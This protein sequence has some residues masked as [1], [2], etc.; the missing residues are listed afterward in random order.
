MPRGR[1]GIRPLQAFGR[2]LKSTARAT[3]KSAQILAVKSRISAKLREADRL[4]QSIG[5]RYYQGRKK[6]SAVSQLSGD[7]EPL[8]VEIDR[9]MSEVAALEAEEKAVRESP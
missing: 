1:C 9:L 6:G 2:F 3:R 8:V 5:E 4:Y 7:T